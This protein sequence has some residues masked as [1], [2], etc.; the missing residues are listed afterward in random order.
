[1]AQPVADFAL[2]QNGSVVAYI[3][4]VITLALRSLSLAWMSVLA[5][6]VLCLIQADASV[7]LVQ[8]N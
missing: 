7:N 6:M 5:A 2:L 8:S 1:M 3:A 4:G